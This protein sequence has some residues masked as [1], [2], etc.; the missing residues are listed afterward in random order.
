ME[1]QSDTKWNY[2]KE[3]KVTLKDDVWNTLWDNH[4]ATIDISFS[5]NFFQNL[6]H[7]NT[8]GKLLDKDLTTGMIVEAMSG[9]LMDSWCRVLTRSCL[10][11][12]VSSCSTLFVFTTSFFRTK[13]I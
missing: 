2:M 12:P 6:P 3:R 5:H 13:T 7:F 4:L 9:N 10:Y 1:E 8:R 11:F